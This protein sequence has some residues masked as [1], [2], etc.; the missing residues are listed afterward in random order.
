MENP[1]DRLDR[2][3]RAMVAVLIVALT[4]VMAYLPLA[5]LW[6][7]ATT[8][9]LPTIRAAFLAW[10]SPGSSTTRWSVTAK[11][12]TLDFVSSLGI[13]SLLLHVGALLAMATLH[14]MLGVPLARP[15]AIGQR[16][17]RLIAALFLISL[18]LRLI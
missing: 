4:G 8:G 11:P 3:D 18:L 2:F 6:H 1:L 13:Y 7:F 10:G 16:L 12:W 9:E 15:R 17:K 5:S 14:V